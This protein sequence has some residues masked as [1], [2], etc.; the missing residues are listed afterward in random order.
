[1][2]ITHKPVEVRRWIQAH[3]NPH[4]MLYKIEWLHAS[5]GEKMLKIFE[6]EIFVDTCMVCT[7]FGIGVPWITDWVVSLK[8]KFG[9][10]FY[11]VQ[12]NYTR[13]TLIQK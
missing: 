12:K 6:V 9:R 1:M 2:L 7:N 8:R 3:G 11:G 5:F 4:T 10:V 13:F